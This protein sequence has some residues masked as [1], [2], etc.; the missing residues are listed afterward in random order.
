MRRGHE[1][2][3]IS[4]LGILSSDSK[5][6][7]RNGLQFRLFPFIRRYTRLS[8]AI[9]TSSRMLVH[10]QFTPYAVESFSMLPFGLTYFLTHEHD[11]VAIIGM[12][13]SLARIAI[14]GSTILHYQGG[15]ISSWQIRY[16]RRFPPNCIIACSKYAE[17]QISINRIN[18]PIYSVPNGVDVDL[19]HPDFILRHS[20][21]DKL[22]VSDKDVVLYV[23]RFSE[24]KGIENLI[25]AMSILRYE[26]FNSVLILIGSGPLQSKYQALAEEYRIDMIILSS[27]PNSLLPAFYN[28]ADVFALPSLHEPAAI[29]L[30]EAQACGLPVIAT[31]TGGTPERVK[32]QITGLLIPPKDPKK[33][34]EAISFLL[35]NDDIRKKMGKEARKYVLDNFNWEN[36]TSKILKIYQQIHEDSIYYLSSK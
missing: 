5:K 33:L 2:I 23:G 36:I 3:I 10:S 15:L 11:I 35:N 7:A 34:A 27:M 18:C 4:G 24:E 31:N 22:Q 14:K 20:I 19:F 32:D 8:N 25:R 28:A 17:E 6:L 1:V 12:S 9:L 16:L 26:N 30:S 21:R 29:V 13:D